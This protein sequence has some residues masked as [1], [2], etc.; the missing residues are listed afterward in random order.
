[1]MLNYLKLELRR[2]SRDGGY[3]VMTLIS[4]LVMYLV[5]TNLGG[6]TGK[7]HHDA[8]VYSMV[9]MAGF[10]ALGAVLASGVGVAEDKTL[11]WLRQLRLTPL[12]PLQVVVARG[13]TG[14][15]VAILPIAAICTAG[16]VFDGVSLSAGQ[17]VA[18]V[19]LLWA[20]IVPIALLGLGSGY[21]FSPQKAQLVGMT[22]YMGMSLLGGLWVPVSKFPHWL[23]DISAVTPVNRYADLPLRV[24][25]GGTPSMV[26][27]AVLVA[28]GAAFAAL[29]VHAYRVSARTA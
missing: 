22:G 13:L 14:M 27:V 1:M 8:A 6:L 11:G 12:S 5:F 16:A 4:P 29:A 9:G 18:I 19:A 25:S 3:L 10:G 28:W 15:T 20:G 26:S 23:R 2:V 24:V 7:D 17:W 21:L